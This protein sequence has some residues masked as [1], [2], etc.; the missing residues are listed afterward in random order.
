MLPESM[1]ESMRST[2]EE[3]ILEQISKLTE[4][5]KGL[6]E[7]IQ[8]QEENQRLRNGDIS[9]NSNV[10][11]LEIESILDLLKSQLEDSTHVLLSEIKSEFYRLINFLSS[12]SDTKAQE[13][14]LKKMKEELSELITFSQ[15]EKTES[16]D[17]TTTEKEYIERLMG[18]IDER[19][20]LIYE[21][22]DQVV[23]LS[24]GKTEL[25]RELTSLKEE[26]EKW[27]RTK[28]IAFKLISTDPRYTI[29]NML[30]Q[31][32]TISQ[33]QLSFVLGISL[34]Q[35]KRYIREL[36]EIEIV[37]INDDGTVELNPTFDATIL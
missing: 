18:M 34:S 25:E 24:V 3:K 10:M 8:K 31:L 20:Q 29:I 21:L 19:E 22:S 36:E 11:G 9:T 7:K 2:V 17:K 5:I 32:H 1:D 13:H 16:L 26:A 35:T 33:M 27:K 30:R 37:R 15:E 12:S 23:A 28:E 4:E 14:V 6:K